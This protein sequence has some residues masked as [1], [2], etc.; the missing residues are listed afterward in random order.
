MYTS[1]IININ[2]RSEG[3]YMFRK[4]T[5]SYISMLPGSQFEISLTNKSNSPVDVEIGFYEKIGT[6]KVAPTSTVTLVRPKLTG[7]LFEMKDVVIPF[8]ATVRILHTGVTL[9]NVTPVP[10]LRM[11]E[12]LVHKPENAWPRRHFTDDE[13]SENIH[14]TITLTS[15]DHT[16]KRRLGSGRS[17]SYTDEAVSYRGG[18]FQSVA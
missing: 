15:R 3:S 16:G 14:H 1:D 18:K 9:E 6:W 4:G 5:H 13:I 7:D 2:F 17:I 12:T 10:H 11:H 8:Y